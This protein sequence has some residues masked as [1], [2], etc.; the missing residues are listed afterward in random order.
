MPER[1]VLHPPLH[2]PEAF[3]NPD[4]AVDKLCVLYDEAVRFLQQSFVDA[5][6]IHERPVRY[7]AYY[8]QIRVEVLSHRRIDSRLSFGRVGAPGLYST[9]ITQ[10]QLFRRYLTEQI[11]LFVGNY[12]AAIEVASSNV[13]IPVQ[14]ALEQVAADDL[15]DPADGWGEAIRNHFDMPDLAIINDDVV[16]GLTRRSESG[17]LPLA[18]FPAPRVDYSLARLRHYTATHYRHFQP[19]VLF[20]NYQHYVEAFEEYARNALADESSDYCCLVTPGNQELTDPSGAIAPPARA[21]QMPAYHL[22]RRNGNGI[23]L[24]NIGVGPSNAKTATDHVA[25]LRSNVWLMLGHCAGLRGGQHL[26]DY[27]LAHAYLRRDQV[28]DEDLPVWVPVPA[29]AEVQKAVENAVGRITSSKGY[30]LKTVMRTG[31]VASVDNRN[32][33][34]RASEGLTRQ[35]SQSRAIALDMESATI[36]ANGFRFRIPYGTLLCVSDKPLHGELKLPGMASR[37]YK[38]QVERHLLIGIKALESLREMPQ[39]YLHSR[40]LRSFSETAFR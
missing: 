27:V 3:R 38:T 12:D 4:E 30:E 23:T 6:G 16:N 18:L 1:R 36:A 14:F 37:F 35:L 8:P 33:E 28:L 22:K 29:L 26:G 24:L 40:K 10:P 34:L 15:V 20:T 7:R 2:P 32:W 17:E 19:L 39:E 21:P 25:V 9:T 13:A 31:T 5:D 11:G